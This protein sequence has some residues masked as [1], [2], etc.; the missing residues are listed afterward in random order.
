MK[1]RMLTQRAGSGGIQYVGDEIDLPEA[2]ARRLIADRQ[3]EPV[4]RPAIESTMIAPPSQNAA[5]PRP[6]PRK[7]SHA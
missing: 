7:K 2:E 1:I 4:T 6:K 5:L 3:A